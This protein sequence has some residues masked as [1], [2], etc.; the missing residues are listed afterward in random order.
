MLPSSPTYIF[1]QVLECT[2]NFTTSSRD[3]QHSIQSHR[4]NNPFETDPDTMLMTENQ[5]RNRTASCIIF[6]RQS[7]LGLPGKKAL[8]SKLRD[9]FGLSKK[10]HQGDFPPYVPSRSLGKNATVVFY[11]NIY[12]SRDMFSRLTEVN[13]ATCQTYT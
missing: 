8:L 10:L 13:M 4:T 6:Q 11:T 12:V 9:H 2:T 5:S 1:A 7:A 3:E